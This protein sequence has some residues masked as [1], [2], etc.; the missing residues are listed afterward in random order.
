[1]REGRFPVEIANVFGGVSSSLSFFL[2]YLSSI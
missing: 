1:M 2:Y